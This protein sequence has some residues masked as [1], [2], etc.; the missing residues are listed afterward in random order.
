MSFE[1]ERPQ[2]RAVHRDGI[3][4][5][6][7]RSRGCVL[8][9]DWSCLVFTS[10]LAGLRPRCRSCEQDPTCF[11][12]A[13]YHLKSYNDI[14]TDWSL[15]YK[16]VAKISAQTKN[17]K[18][19]KKIYTLTHTQDV[20]IH[21]C[22]HTPTCRHTHRHLQVSVLVYGTPYIETHTPY[23]WIQD[24]PKQ[25]ETRLRSAVSRRNRTRGFYFQRRTSLRPHSG[26]TGRGGGG[27]K[28]KNCHFL[29]LSH[30]IPPLLHPG[31]NERP[32]ALM[33]REKYLYRVLIL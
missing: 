13:L 16:F 12:I 25:M 26:R 32:R 21:A 19:F 14:Y 22:M 18:E 1:G 28:R 4:G 7:L 3:R 10:P 23:V 20:I 29:A 5:R 24:E 6:R 17:E 30:P 2:G 15:Y 11:S 33:I 8:G 9:S 31:G 27:G